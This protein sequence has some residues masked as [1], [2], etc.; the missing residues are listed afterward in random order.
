MQTNAHAERNGNHYFVQ[1]IRQ[2]N[3]WSVWYSFGRVYGT[4]RLWSH[5]LAKNPNELKCTGL[6]SEPKHSE[7]FLHLTWI[8]I[9]C[10]SLPTPPRIRILHKRTQH[11]IGKHL[12]YCY[13]RDDCEWFSRPYNAFTG[14]TQKVNKTIYI[15]HNYINNARWSKMPWI[16]WN[17]GTGITGLNYLI[18]CHCHSDNWDTIYHR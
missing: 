15:T 18:S 1:W 5:F 3:L 17:V 8:G 12:K 11:L 10:M 13:G 6:S 14:P 4:L 16:D 7:C 9:G 2:L